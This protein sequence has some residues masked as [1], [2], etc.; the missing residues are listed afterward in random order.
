LFLQGPAQLTSLRDALYDLEN[1]RKTL[2]R[3]HKLMG[4]LVGQL[5][6]MLGEM[7]SGDEK[8]IEGG[9]GL[10]GHHDDDVAL[11]WVLA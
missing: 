6:E 3:I 9:E 1:P 10:E 5:E 4:E 7:G 8:R 2:Q 11:R